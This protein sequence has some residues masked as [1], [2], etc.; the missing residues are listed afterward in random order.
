MIL[1]T[2]T[3]APVFMRCSLAPLGEAQRSPFLITNSCSPSRTGA[4]PQPRGRSDRSDE[5]RRRRRSRL[6]HQVG[7]PDALVGGKRDLPVEQKHLAHAGATSSPAF[8]P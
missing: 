8:G 4:G 5:V 7:H 6:E 2:A 1:T 3:S